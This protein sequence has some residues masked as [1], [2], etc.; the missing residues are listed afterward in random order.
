MGRLFGGPSAGVGSLGVFGCPVGSFL[1]VFGGRFRGWFGRWSVVLGVPVGCPV[2]RPLVAV[3]GRVLSSGFVC[4]LFLFVGSCWRPLG[5][6]VWSAWFSVLGFGLLRCRWPLLGSSWPF[7]CRRGFRVL[8]LALWVRGASLPGGRLAFSVFG[9]WPGF[10]GASWGP[11]WGLVVVFGGGVRPPLGV[12]DP[13]LRLRS[14]PSPSLL[15][16]GGGGLCDE[17]WRR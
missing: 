16:S 17:W 5:R 15:S 14:L 11:G 13:W 1:F 7:S 8:V 3:S 4:V 9:F 10:G 12:I 6:P 2:G